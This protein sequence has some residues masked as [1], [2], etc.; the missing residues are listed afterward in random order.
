MSSW[1]TVKFVV[2]EIFPDTLH[3][4]QVATAGAMLTC[5]AIALNVGPFAKIPKTDVSTENS[6][7]RAVAVVSTPNPLT[8]AWPEAAPGATP[9][10][11]QLAAD[12]ARPVTPAA[13]SANVPL[14]K[15]APRALLGTTPLATPAVLTDHDSS[16]LSEPA[17]DST[18]SI[19]LAAQHQPADANSDLAT[20]VGVWAPNPGSCSARDFRE[21]ALP[22]V[23]SADGASAGETFCSFSNKKQTESGWSV[24]AR[25]TNQKEHWTTKVQLTV[26]DNRLTWT[27]RRGTQA[28]TRCAPD[29]LM[30]AAR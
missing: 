10:G 21:G 5:V 28:Y 3:L 19:E 4:H 13:I 16:G 8:T 7:R 24:L 1:E 2:S 20:I 30:A 14:P 22:A 17:R 26:K 23:I 29:V 18:A 9:D 15:S 12:T 27:S 25:C 11:P 6:G